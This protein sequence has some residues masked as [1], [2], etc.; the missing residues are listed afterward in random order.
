MVGLFKF[1]ALFFIGFLVFACQPS[2]KKVNRQVE[3]KQDTLSGNFI[4]NGVNFNGW[5][6][7]QFGTQGPVLISEGN[8][9]LN[10]GDGLTGVTYQRDFPKINYQLSLEAK[11]V[12]GNDFFCGLTF[13]VNQSFCSFIVGGWGGP[14]VGLSTIDGKDASENDT[15]ILKNFEKN[16]WYK[17]KLEVSE[18]K[19]C[20]W[21]D[22]E[23]VLDFSIDEHKLGIRPEVELSKPF[24]IASWNTTAALRNIELK[25]LE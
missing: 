11:K 14:V 15:R 7:T 4:F 24:G 18:N 10:F 21:I 23:Q 13:P 5:E 1:S 19:I 9:I 20:A 17:I 16:V 25:A 6:I 3:I 22:D 2:S 12:S 8:I